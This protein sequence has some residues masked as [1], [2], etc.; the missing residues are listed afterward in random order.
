MKYEVKLPPEVGLVPLVV[1][2]FGAWEDDARANLFEIVSHQGRNSAKN[3]NSLKQVP[4]GNN[5]ASRLID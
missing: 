5:D 4:Q 1:S 3:S 2:T